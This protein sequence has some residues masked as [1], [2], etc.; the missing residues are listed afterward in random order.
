MWHKHW[1][2][3]LAR[4]SAFVTRKDQLRALVYA[5]PEPASPLERLPRPF[6]T[7]P[8]LA[9]VRAAYA[10]SEFVPARA[11]SSEKLGPAWSTHWLRGAFR[12]PER[13]S[14]RLGRGGCAVALR[15]DSSCEAAAWDD[16]TGAVVASFTGTTDDTR[17]DAHRAGPLLR[18]PGERAVLWFEVACNEMFG[19]TPNWDCGPAPPESAREYA[20]RRAEIALYDEQAAALLHDLTFLHDLAK[21][22]QPRSQTAATALYAADLA[23][24]ACDLSRAEQTVPAALAITRSCIEGLCSSGGP[25][26][27]AVCA[28]G[29]CHIDTAWL[30]PYRETRRK[31]ARS[32][33]AQLALAS[34]SD[35]AH[36]FAI[37]QAQQVAW[38]RADYP[39]LYERV[40]AAVASGTFV[41]VGGTWVEMDCNIPSGEALVRQFS[42]GQREFQAAFGRRCDVFWLPDTFGYSAQLPQI[43][44]SAG[45]KYFLTQK[46]SWNQYNKWPYSTFRWE[47]LDGSQVLTHFPPAD[48]YTGR[49]DVEQ[50]L[51]TETNNKD[52][53]RCAR[54][55]MLYGHGD[56]GGGPQLEMIERLQR[57]RLG[58]PGLPTIKP[59]SPSDF[60]AE[61]EKDWDKLLT[62]SGELYFECHRGTYTSQ[63]KN[64]LEN[65]KCEN[66]LHDAEFASVCATLFHGAEYPYDALDDSWKLLLLNQFH[67]VLPGSSIGMV[68]EDSARDYA[69]IH[70]IAEPLVSAACQKLGR[71]FVLNT[72][73]FPRVG[74]VQLGST[75]LGCKPLQTA[76]D[77][78]PLVV[79]DVAETSWSSIGPDS[80][81]P[82]ES[83]TCVDK[84]EHIFL[85]NAAFV[86]QFEK[87]S[88][89][90]VSLIHKPSGREVVP[91]GSKS[92]RFVLF[93]DTPNYWDAWD[94]DV[95]HL[96]KEVTPV[97][98]NCS[99]SVLESGPVRSVVQFSFDLGERCSVTNTVVLT[100]VSKKLE[101]TTTVKWSEE[102]KFLKVEFPTT[103]RCATA[104]Y[105]T[106][107]GFIDRP[108]HAN[109][110]WDMAKFEVCGHRWADLSEYNFGLSVINDCKYGY[111]AQTD[112]EALDFNFPLRLVD[113]SGA[114]EA[115]EDSGSLVQVIAEGVFVEAIK[116]A[117]DRS[118][119]VIVRLCERFGGS[120]NAK[121]IFSPKLYVKGAWMSNV[122]EEKLSVVRFDVT[123]CTSTVLTP[124]QVL[125]LRLKL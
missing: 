77:G 2:T 86:A 97:Q 98:T 78:S 54:S 116:L 112:Q 115:P 55:I 85:E 52:K 91:R 103:I 22:R 14:A 10:R 4:V 11:D 41:P 20:L 48:T 74:V 88:G 65:R 125:T 36:R 40:Q 39:Q 19:N 122:L 64:K 63:A 23:V 28:V 117:D 104:A 21:A 50:S 47:G 79:V 69:E 24:N 53:E 123:N 38:L 94:V 93:D 5:D 95:F 25:S 62:W 66:L 121:I 99:C 31:V 26:S 81:Q 84:G 1:D 82:Q 16:A 51:K 110:S 92:N 59:G 75:P 89:V 9:D 35:G 13:W 6:A 71:S 68:Y 111:A 60:F 106:Q 90:L 34:E 113:N 118:G 73:C 57:L 56:G 87:A 12:V 17:R 46:L 105:D 27:H 108:T 70:K 102:H 18:A 124:F 120:A 7:P 100:C 42:Y 45:I 109:T 61:C 49:C 67:D 119:D 80:V 114:P 76:R 8:S 43:M 101:F 3:T 96:E 33:S 58:V 15:W 29:N 44:T 32:W 107:F 37:S 72:L 30:W 83:V